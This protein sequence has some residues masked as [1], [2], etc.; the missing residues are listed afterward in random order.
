MTN[1]INLSNIVILITIYLKER[2]YVFKGRK[3][4][5]YTLTHKYDNICCLHVIHHFQN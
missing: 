1:T 5:N 2:I 3:Y 4:M